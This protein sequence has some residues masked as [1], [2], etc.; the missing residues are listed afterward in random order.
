VRSEVFAIDT[1]VPSTTHN[2]TACQKTQGSYCVLVRK[3]QFGVASNCSSKNCRQCSSE[4]KH[5][6]VPSLCNSPNLNWTLA[7][8][9]NNLAA[10]FFNSK[11]NQRALSPISSIRRFLD[12]LYGLNRAILYAFPQFGLPGRSGHSSISSEIMEHDLHNGAPMPRLLKSWPRR[13]R[14]EARTSTCL[15][16]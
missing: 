4:N 5:R 13:L 9:T 16:T 2:A 11:R 12:L 14:D 6:N 3:R 15:P 10:S 8:I 7:C 1:V